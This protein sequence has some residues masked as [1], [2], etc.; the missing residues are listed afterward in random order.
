M[1]IILKDQIIKPDVTLAQANQYGIKEEIGMG[2]SDYSHSIPERVHNI[3]LASSKF[4]GVLIL[5]GKEFSFNDTVG[6][7][8]SLTGYKPA[9]IIKNGKT[10]LGDGGGVCQVSTTIFRAVLNAGLTITERNAH[11]YRVSYYENDSKPGF[12]ATVF[13]PTADLKFLNDTQAAI[14]IQTEIDQNNHILNFRLYGEKDGRQ[15][16]ISS[17]SLYDQIPPPPPIYQDDPTL[18]RGVVKQ[19]DFAAWGAKASFNYKVVRDGQTIFQK[20]FYSN[21]RPWQA[22]YSVGTAD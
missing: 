16:T 1:T 7:I 14:L 12:D 4:D 3:T 13:D 19:I 21:Y 9:Y 15:S 5:K 20:T 6:D 18:K 11:A 22:V 8:S 2:K 10:V 17:I